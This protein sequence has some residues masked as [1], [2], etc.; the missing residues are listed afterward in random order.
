MN[1]TDQGAMESANVTSN[2]GMKL[3]FIAKSG[4]KWDTVSLAIPN[5]RR[6][7]QNIVREQ[8]GPS[9]RAR[10]AKTIEEI[11][12]LF[13]TNDMVEMTVKYTNQGQRLTTA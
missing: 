11:F 12:N 9:G 8:G 7:Q 10:E 3:Q 6:L 13:V 2:T 1:A 5:R 4:M